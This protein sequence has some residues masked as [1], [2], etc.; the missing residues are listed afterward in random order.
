MIDISISAQFNLISK[1]TVR[2]LYLL[3]SKIMAAR[4]RYP[5]FGQNGAALKY[6][7]GLQSAAPSGLSWLTDPLQGS[8]SSSYGSYGGGYGLDPGS[9]F[10][11]D[12]CPDLILAAIAAAAAAAAFLIYNAI[13]AAGRRRKRSGDSQDNF[14]LTF[15]QEVR[16]HPLTQTILGWR[17]FSSV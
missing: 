3:R 12:I 1:V 13:V 10:S 15:L 11:L 9:C 4:L 14:F 2:F 6:Q 5:G 16:G 7:A 17:H 8:S